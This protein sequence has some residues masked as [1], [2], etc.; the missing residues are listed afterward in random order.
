MIPSPAASALP[1]RAGE[2]SGLGQ[3]QLL[4]MYRAMLLIRT[5]DERM[6]TLQRQGRVGFYGACTGQEAACIGSVYALR[7]TDWIFPALRE[8]A[9]M[10]MRG[11]PLVHYIAQVFGNSGDLTKGRQMPSHQA[12]RSVNQVSWSSCIGTQLSQAVGAAWRRSSRASV[13]RLRGAVALR[14]AVGNLREPSP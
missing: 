14:Q 12:A 3:A 9:A 5:L 11:F 2:R 10:L 13:R 8:G 6:M 7:P 4:E 1:G